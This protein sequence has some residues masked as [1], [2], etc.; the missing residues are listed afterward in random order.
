MRLEKF[1]GFTTTITITTT[2]TTFPP[3]VTIFEFA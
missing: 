1:A 2:T 3:I